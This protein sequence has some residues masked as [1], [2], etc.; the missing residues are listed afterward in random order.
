MS[1]PKRTKAKKIRYTHPEF[2][3]QLNEEQIE[4]KKVILD[5]EISIIIGKAGTGKCVGPDTLLTIYLCKN[6][7]KEI[8]LFLEK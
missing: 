6:L 5:N 1:K 4:A 2:N 7:K 3:I 8:E